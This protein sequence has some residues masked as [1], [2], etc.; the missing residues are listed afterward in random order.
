MLK[1]PVFIQ[2]SGAVGAKIGYKWRACLEV[3]LVEKTP[4]NL[5]SLFQSVSCRATFALDLGIGEWLAWRLHGVASEPRTL[6]YLEAL[7]ASSID[8]RYL[9]VPLPD[10]PED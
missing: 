4:R 10:Q 5:Q 1:V 9:K 3:H 8:E 7:W 2:R 6:F